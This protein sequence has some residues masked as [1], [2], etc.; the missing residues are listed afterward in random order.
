MKKFKIAIIAPVPFYYHVPLYKS[1][2]DDSRMELQVIY[3][4]DETLKGRDVE[5]MYQAKGSIVDKENLLKGYTY[6]FLK[7]YSF[8]PSFMSWPFGLINFGIWSEIKSNKYD[9]VILQS[10]T[11]LTWWIAF[12][13]CLKFKS[14]VFFMTDSNVL[15]ES[16]KPIFK[17]VIKRILLGGFLFKKSRGFLTSGT[18]N[19]LFYE[20][21]G[22]SKD[23]LARLRFSWGYNEVLAKAKSFMK[24]REKIR[25]S[26]GISKNDFV[27]LYVGRFSH[28]KSPLTILQ[29]YDKVNFKNKKLFLVG[30]G[31][32]RSEI[33]NTIKKLQLEKVCLVGF[34]PRNEVFEFYA[35]ADVLALPSLAETWGIVINEALCFSLPVIAS[36]QVGAAVDLIKEGENGFIFPVG[37]YSKLALY[38][39]KIIN[40]P[41]RERKELSKKSLQ[42]ITQWVKNVDPALQLLN[43]LKIF[44][45]NLNK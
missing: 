33:E 8:M 29:A 40:A 37:D 34:K 45:L 7:N 9:A 18:A 22:V 3:C 28:E 30:D 32:Q 10:W 2:G 27:I 42:I 11:N 24:N 43:I 15:A 13:A 25:N 21:Y 20:Y 14:P 41:T 1:F 12:I 35:S 4:S 36:D 39:E 31:P 19:E 16:S 5:K 23:K 44:K 17:K 38:I 6:K 26:L